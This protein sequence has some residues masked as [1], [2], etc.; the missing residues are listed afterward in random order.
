MKSCRWEQAESPKRSCYL[1]GKNII[2]AIKPGAV[3]GVSPFPQRSLLNSAPWGSGSLPR[4]LRTAAPEPFLSGGL[5]VGPPRAAAAS[6]GPAR[7]THTPRPSQV[8]VYR[9]PQG[10]GAAVAAAGRRAR[11]SRWYKPL[12]P[13]LPRG[14]P[15]ERLLSASVPQWPVTEARVRCEPR[16][17]RDSPVRQVRPQL[18][19]RGMRALRACA[20][21]RGTTPA[22]GADGGVGTTNKMAGWVGD[23]LGQ[24]FC[25]ALSLERWA[26]AA[27]PGRKWY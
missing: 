4:R 24:V 27:R 11:R 23:M 2:S 8:T 5:S 22:R 20:L 1:H 19:P 9:Q 6:V 3:W 16:T 25:T 15:S 14:R 17:R 7:E 18:R 26:P 21:R 10:H 13:A 12:S